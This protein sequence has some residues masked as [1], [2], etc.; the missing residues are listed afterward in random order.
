MGIPV[1]GYAKKPRLMFS[2]KS[3]SEI[4]VIVGRGLNGLL[5][6]ENIRAPEPNGCHS[7]ILYPGCP[8]SLGR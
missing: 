3:E 8:S 1:F 6:F 5:R 2:A 7:G 4:V